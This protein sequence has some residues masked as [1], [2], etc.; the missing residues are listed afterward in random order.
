MEHGQGMEV[1]RLPELAIALECTVT[2]LLGMTSE[3][4]SW[5]PDAGAVPAPQ[6]AVAVT[7]A[8]DHECWL[9]H[10]EADRGAFDA[11]PVSER[12]NGQPASSRA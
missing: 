10:S 1:G 2:Y 11:D 3:P 12:R 4:H 8:A 7:V 6:P 9:H 5:A